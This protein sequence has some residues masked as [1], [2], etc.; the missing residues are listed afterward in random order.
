MF[1]TPEEKLFILRMIR[2]A[3]LASTDWTDLPSCPLDAAT[4]A[5]FASYRQALRNLP[6]TL[7]LDL[8]QI[9]ERGNVLNLH[10][11][12]PVSPVVPHEAPPE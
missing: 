12:L 11:I 5:E 7:D 9:D 8:M 10:E 6:S 2:N 1:D 4:K 3:E